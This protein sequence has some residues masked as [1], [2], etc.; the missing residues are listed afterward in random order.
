[1]YSVTRHR[2]KRFIWY[3]WS[4]SRAR[5][6]HKRKLAHIAVSAD[7]SS[8]WTMMITNFDMIFCKVSL[9]W[10]L[11]TL[12]GIWIL[13]VWRCYSKLSTKF[14]DTTQGSR[15]KKWRRI[16]HCFCPK[17]KSIIRKGTSLK[18]VMTPQENNHIYDRK[19]LTHTYIRTC[20]HLSHLK[21]GQ[22]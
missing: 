1:M 21:Y 13:L 8:A 10:S 3:M 22:Q 5:P 11:I 7:V 15:S 17:W 6:S 2:V 4:S 20:A 16:R 18:S 12:K 9:I 14:R 19:I